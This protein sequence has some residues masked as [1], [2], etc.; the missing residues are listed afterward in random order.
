MSFDPN[1][2]SPMWEALPDSAKDSLLGPPSKELGNMIGDIV[3]I[4]GTPFRMIK[5]VSDEKVEQF[6]KRTK[7]KVS[8][9]PD[10][11]RDSTKLPIAVKTIEDAKYSLNDEGMQ[12]IFLT[13]LLT[14]STTQRM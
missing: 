5:I 3:Y 6:A 7:E 10:E 11:N 8:A 2:F 13:L 14:A 12:E 4:L 9:I 1:Q